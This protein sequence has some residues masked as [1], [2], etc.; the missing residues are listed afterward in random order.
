MALSCIEKYTRPL[1]PG[2]LKRLRF[3]LLE[4][5]HFRAAKVGSIQHANRQYAAAFHRLALDL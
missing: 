4:A 5:G 2:S 1:S 3:L